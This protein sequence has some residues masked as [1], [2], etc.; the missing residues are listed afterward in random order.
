[1]AMATSTTSTGQIG[2]TAVFVWRA[3][4]EKGPLS[5]P[6]LVK[7]T[8]APRDN[9]MQAVGWLARENKV[10]IEE[11]SRGRIVSLR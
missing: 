7:E 10:E 8:G 1:M 4:H 11:T 3:L 6:K 9:V 2:E 5:Y